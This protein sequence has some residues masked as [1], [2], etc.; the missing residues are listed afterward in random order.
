MVTIASSVLL[1]HLLAASAIANEPVDADEQEDVL[2]VPGLEAGHTAISARVSAYA[3]RLDS[4]FG[5]ERSDEVYNDTRLRLRLGGKLAEGGRSES[6]GRLRLNLSLPRATRRVSLIVTSLT[7]DD[8]EDTP[9]PAPEE[10]DVTAALRVFLLDRTD[11]KI[12]IDAGLG[13]RPEPDPRLRLR[14]HRAFVAGKTT[15]RP[16]QFF[17]WQGED[18]F[19]A[20]TRVDVD[21]RLDER[22]LG[23]FNTQS[24]WSEKINGV[25][26]E[27]SLAYFVWPSHKKAYRLRF[28]ALGETRPS[29]VVTEY[30]LG[31]RYRRLIH[32]DWL[33]LD[34]EPALEFL[35]EDEFDTSPAITVQLE[36][37]FGARYLTDAR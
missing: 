15:L 3:D 5:D 21:R 25:A 2:D 12:N 24:D 13:F 11:S 34:V 6:V 37:N 8:F 30:Q 18:G 4:F 1:V 32:R 33:Y 36:A 28:R 31:F 27:A 19:G 17:R 29:T 14:G 35:R 16:T 7:D 26:L 22:S 9:T 10:D 23:R 20:R